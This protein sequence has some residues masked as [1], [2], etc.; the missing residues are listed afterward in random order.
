ML[1][2]GI[3]LLTADLVWEYIGT[4]LRNWLYMKYV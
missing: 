1:S 2:C 3:E 4:S